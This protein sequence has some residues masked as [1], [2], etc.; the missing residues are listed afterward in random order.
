MN[1]P[2]ENNRNF[3]VAALL[4]W[5]PIAF[6]RARFIRLR[7]YRRSS[8]NAVADDFT[9][10]NHQPFTPPQISEPEIAI[11]ASSSRRIEIVTPRMNR[12]GSEEVLRELA[13]QSGLSGL[14]TR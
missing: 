13:M 6:I 1:T 7:D 14:N 9:T 4:A 11:T 12:Y 8:S 2:T 3:I 10:T 5:W